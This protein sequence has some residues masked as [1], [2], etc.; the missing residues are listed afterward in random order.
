MRLMKYLG[1]STSLLS[2][3]VMA[4]DGHI[5]ANDDLSWKGSL[6]AQIGYFD[7][8]NSTQNTAIPGVLLGSEAHHH[9]KGLQLM[10]GEL[11]LTVKAESMLTGNIIIGSHHG[12]SLDIEELWLQPDIT[13]SI[14]LRLGTQLSDIGL[15]NAYHDHDW[16]FMDANLSQQAFLAGQYRDDSLHFS[17]LGNNQTIATWVGRGS[18]YPASTQTDSSSPHAYGASYQW[19][20]NSDTISGRI[21][22]S[23]AHFKASQRGNDNNGGHNHSHGNIPTISFTGNT[24][25]ITLGSQWQWKSLGWDIEWMTQNIDAEITDAQQIKAKL[26][27]TQQGISSQAYWNWDKLQIALRYD[28]LITNNKVTKKSTDF[29]QALNSQ[30]HNPERISLAFNWRFQENQQIRLQ[31]NYDKTQQE[32]EQQFWLVYQGTLNYTP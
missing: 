7:S 2:P 8:S 31:G 32:E 25:L 23:F 22:T 18:A 6:F 1:L 17:W 4:H 11:A 27:A 24:N 21:K 5:H 30:G 29:E 9:E 13:E 16:V 3:L 10:H 26:D 12:E 19:H 28:T 20:W 14:K 15:Y